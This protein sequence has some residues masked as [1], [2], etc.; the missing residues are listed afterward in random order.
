MRYLDR[1]FLSCLIV[2]GLTARAFAEEFEGIIHS[3]NVF[4]SN[5]KD[6]TPT[7]AEG[8]VW[9]KGNKMRSEAVF[10]PIVAVSIVDL[11]TNQSIK[12]MPE[13][14]TAIIAPWEPKTFKGKKFPEMVKT[15]KTDIILGY[16]VE[17]FVIRDEGGQELEF[18]A[19]TELN[20][21]RSVR[22][23]YSSGLPQGEGS[24]E[25]EFFKKG[26]F[27]LRSV[28]KA[29]DG[30]N[31]FR[32]DITKV[33]KMPL[34]ASLFVVPPDYQRVEKGTAGKTGDMGLGRKDH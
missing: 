21:S 4:Y 20:I 29:A 6:H 12:L 8:K 9:F 28:I 7:T 30:S 14:K 23:A 25:T 18:W 17:Q 34:D 10:G 26:Y 3:S 13:K 31:K 22:Q 11:D 27:P 2:I 32:L 19:T 15:G 16:P 24:S 1:V 33:E 5:T